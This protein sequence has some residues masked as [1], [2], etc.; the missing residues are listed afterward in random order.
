MAK[1][2]YYNNLDLQNVRDKRKFWKAIEPVFT[3]KIQFTKHIGL[4][5]NG[6]IVA[7]IKGVAEL[8]N[9]YF[10]NITYEP[11]IAENETYFTPMIGTND[12]IAIAIERYKYHPSIKMIKEHWKS[13]EVF[14]F[15]Q[16][17]IAEVQHY[18]E[19]LNSKKASPINSISGKVLKQSADI[20]APTLECCFNASVEKKHFTE[21]LK[22]GDVTSIFK[23]RRCFLLKKL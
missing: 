11:E 16:V 6:E 7:D 12:L 19:K 14:Q 5:E 21:T 1:L 3:G 22:A 13:S 10:A 15:R 20:F 4:A 23:K 9:E 8:L 2:N 17:N 18:L